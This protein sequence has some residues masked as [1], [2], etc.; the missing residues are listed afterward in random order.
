MSKLPVSRA[1]YDAVV[2]DLQIANARIQELE[3]NTDNST[4]LQQQLTDAVNEAENLQEQLTEANATI[5]TN[6]QRIAELESDVASLRKNPAENSGNINTT[7]DPDHST[8]N[9]DV[10]I[11]NIDSATTMSD[12]LAIYRS[13]KIS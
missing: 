2:N 1:K 7:G 11:Q 5:Q 3:A 13:K 10:F 12:A 4:E 6:A 8:D 9:E